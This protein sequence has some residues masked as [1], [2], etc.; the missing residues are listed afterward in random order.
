VAAQDSAVDSIIGVTIDQ[1][2]HEVQALFDQWRELGINAVVVGEEMSSSRG[3]R[4][5]ARKNGTRLF[6]RF[7]FFSPP[8]ELAAD[9]ELVAIT[10]EGEPARDGSTEFACPSRDD[11]R[12]SRIESALDLVRRLRP[13]GIVLENI[14]QFVAWESLGPEDDPTLLPETCFCVHCLQGFASFLGVP[15]STIPPQ[16]KRA[17]P[18]IRANVA[19]Q[20][21]QFRVE[22]I[23]S[24]VAEIAAAVRDVDP[25]VRIIVNVLPWRRDDYAGAG[26]WVTGQDLPVMAQAAD[27]LSPMTFS[28][29]LGH[30]PEWI[31]SVVRDIAWAAE[32]P[33]LP[34]VRV[35]SEGGDDG[36]S[37]G[38]VFEAVLR[39]ALQDPS[40]GAVLHS[41][42]DIEADPDRA[43][44]IRR[45]VLER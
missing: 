35:S 5:L 17:A 21:R 20:W 34:A 15:Q 22:T 18:W 16:P 4:A 27:Y 38:T 12:D 44:T 10:E 28:E 1:T 2:D 13:D 33:V 29:V 43:E 36:A 40:A 45:V 8:K 9:P 39:A 37:P 14:H 42:S 30:P 3:F 23:S 6:I 7:P 25:G 11:F 32:C 41:W 24:T 31:G 19:D 26:V